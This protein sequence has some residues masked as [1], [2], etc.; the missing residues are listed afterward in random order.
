MGFMQC[1]ELFVSAPVLR[2]SLFY[3]GRRS[4]VQ[5]FPF[6]LILRCVVINVQ[7]THNGLYRTIATGE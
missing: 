2:T 3:W 6:D 4:L 7:L 5:Q 1:H